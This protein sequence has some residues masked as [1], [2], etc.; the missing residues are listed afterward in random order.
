MEEI[1]PVPWGRNQLVLMLHNG[2]SF[3]CSFSSGNDSNLIPMKKGV[4]PPLSARELVSCTVSDCVTWRVLELI[5]LPP[6]PTPQQ[7]MYLYGA[8]VKIQGP[9]LS[10]YLSSLCSPL[11]TKTLPIQL[12]V[13]GDFLLKTTCCISFWDHLHILWYEISIFWWYLGVEV[14]ALFLYRSSDTFWKPDVIGQF[15][16]NINMGAR[17]SLC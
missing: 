13:S 9:H 6:P 11:V 15:P 3:G 16:W 5:C 2:P 17:G 12:Y 4:Y 1:V 10:L 7:C 8:V 14:T